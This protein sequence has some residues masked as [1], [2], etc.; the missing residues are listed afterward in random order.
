MCKCAGGYTARIRV[1][2]CVRLGH[3]W[4][5]T[6]AH[7]ELGGLVAAVIRGAAMKGCSCSAAVRQPPVAKGPSGCPWHDRHRLNTTAPN[8]LQSTWPAYAIQN[9]LL[10]GLPSTAGAAP[11]WFAGGH[12]FP[13]ESTALL[14]PPSVSSSDSYLHR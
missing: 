4:L 1:V 8:L 2:L 13:A 6:H 12:G 9:G 14:P 7:A 10:L 5:A 11:G 3:G